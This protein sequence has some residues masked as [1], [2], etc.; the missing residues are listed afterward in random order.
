MNTN[1]QT[2]DKQRLLD[3]LV[4]G[5]LS[6]AER[7]ELLAW[8]EREPDGWRRCALAFLEAQDWSSVLGSLAGVSRSAAASER[9]ETST[10]AAGGRTHVRSNPFWNVRQWGTML[11]MAASVVLAFTLGLWIR[12]AGEAGQIAPPGPPAVNVVSNGESFSS[13]ETRVPVAEVDGWTPVE[14]VPDHVRQALERL[15]HQVEQQRR[16][17]PYRLDDGRRVVIPVDQVDV[18]PVE[19]QSYQ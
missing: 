2:T 5:E 19:I 12:D 1:Q 9:T 7:R 13:E 4:D 18:R 6:D 14:A 10:R 16:L 3:L 11:A 15:G 8:C 17:V